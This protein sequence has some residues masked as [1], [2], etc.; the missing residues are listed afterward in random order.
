MDMIRREKSRIQKR[1]QT[2]QVAFSLLLL[3]TFL[4]SI[5]LG[6]SLARSP[7][8]RIAA[9]FYTCWLPLLLCFPCFL[10]VVLGI[11]RLGPYM[12]ETQRKKQDWVN[13][14]G[15]H[16][17]AQLTRHPGENALVIGGRARG[18]GASH[19]VYLNWQDLQTGQLYSF[20]VSTHFS[21]GLRNL[22]EGTLYPVQLDPSD[23]AFFVVPDAQAKSPAEPD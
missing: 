17:L 22:P 20:R 21:S 6:V 12:Q 13:E 14:Y 1:E 11:S 5:T 10:I 15:R 8:A 18:R 4:V 7:V 3:T 9:I 2:A 16:I 23:S 19:R